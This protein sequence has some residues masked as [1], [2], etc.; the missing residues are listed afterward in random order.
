MT[1]TEAARV[2]S[3]LLKKPVRVDWSR[4]LTGEEKLA[5]G[6]AVKALRKAQSYKKEV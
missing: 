1:N 2:I 6:K 4:D 3:E 5:L